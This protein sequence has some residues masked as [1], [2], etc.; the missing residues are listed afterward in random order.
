VKWPPLLFDAPVHNA[1]NARTGWPLAV[2]IVKGIS[3]GRSATTVASSISASLAA[4][5]EFDA[6]LAK[7]GAR[8]RANIDRHLAACQAEPTQD[9]HDLWRR[10]VRML[11]TLAGHAV[12]TAGQQAIQFF[13]ADGKY[14]M[15]VFALEDLRDGKISIFVPDVLKEAMELVLSP[16]KGADPENRLYPIRKGGGEMLEMELLD[17]ATPNPS[18]WFKHML[19]WNRKSLRLMLAPNANEVQIG[20]VERLCAIAAEKWTGKEASVGAK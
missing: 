1:Y 2:R 16:K 19:G 8:D 7:L 10:L 15:Q 6:F 18:P 17:G 5:A 14:R 13:V 4:P 12:Q 9:H 20:A 3:M 11:F